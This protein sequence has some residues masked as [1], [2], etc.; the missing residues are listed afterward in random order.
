MDLYVGEV[1]RAHED[2]EIGIFRHDQAALWAHLRQRELFKS[3]RPGL[4]DPW[5]EEELLELPVHQVLACPAGSG[6][7]PRGW[8]PRPDEIQFFLNDVE[9][10]VWLCRRDASVTRPVNE[11]VIRSRSGIPIIAPEIQLLYKAKH[12]LGKD[13]HDFRLGVDRLRPKQRAWLRDSLE[14]VHPGDPWLERLG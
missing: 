14:I 7:P 3:A 8:E 11:V 10:D 13:E 6:T 5:E 4:W 12:H 9:D 1:T 2:L